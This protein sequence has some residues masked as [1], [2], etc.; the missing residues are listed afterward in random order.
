[1]VCLFLI[2]TNVVHDLRFIVFE[3]ELPRISFSLRVTV[4]YLGFRLM[5]EGHLLC[6]PV[7]ANENI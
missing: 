3:F 4:A 6:I 5:H 2:F 7:T 1:L